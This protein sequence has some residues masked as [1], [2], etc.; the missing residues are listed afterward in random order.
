MRNAT[1]WVVCACLAVAAMASGCANRE[2]IR[3]D[4]GERTHK[5][6][7]AQRAHATATAEPPSGLDS[8]EAA[9]IH[10]QY[11]KD[12]GGGEADVSE[13]QQVLILNEQK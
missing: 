7:G 13:K 4:F 12:L 9:M 10:G 11:R 5:W 8:E 1:G 6:Y 2:H 3:D